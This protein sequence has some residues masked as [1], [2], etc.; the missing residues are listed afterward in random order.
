LYRLQVDQL[1]Q[2]VVTLLQQ[3]IDVGPGFADPV[4]ELHQAV[5][6]HHGPYDG[7][8]GQAEQQHTDDTHCCPPLAFARRL[9]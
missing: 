9:Y 3:H 6:C 7:H 5:V 2:L 8:G 1:R 4:L